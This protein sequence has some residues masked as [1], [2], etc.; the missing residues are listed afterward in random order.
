MSENKRSIKGTFPV[1]LLEELAAFIPLRKRSAVIV[2][3]T[4][5]YVRQLKMLAVLKQS[6][7]AWDDASHPELATA[8]DIHTWLAEKR[9]QWRS[10]P[11]PISEREHA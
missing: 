10:I 7:E 3:A 4:T 1:Q 11:L 5:A 9:A 6:A 2:Q 8:E